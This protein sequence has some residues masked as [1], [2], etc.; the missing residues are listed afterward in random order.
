MR[1][2]G[3]DHITLSSGP[4]RIG[5]LEAMRAFYERVFSFRHVERPSCLEEK[6]EEGEY[7][8]WLEDADGTMQI[9]LICDDENDHA[10]TEVH[11]RELL[12]P[13]DTYAP[14]IAFR[15]SIPMAEIEC[16]LVEKNVP[17]LSKDVL[18]SVFVND[19]NGNMIEISSSAQTRL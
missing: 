15:V 4:P 17:F 18:R 14:H 5:A 9:H 11:R 7:G 19:P 8:M 2:D 1:T 16:E 12:A 13:R 10:K 6:M 3:I